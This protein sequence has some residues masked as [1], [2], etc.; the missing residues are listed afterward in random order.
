MWVVPSGNRI[1]GIW[2]SI[3][4]LDSVDAAHEKEGSFIIP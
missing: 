2:I 1:S 4:S 3:K